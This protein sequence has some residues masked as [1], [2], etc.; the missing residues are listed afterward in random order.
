MPV[1][2]YLTT[3]NTMAQMMTKVNTVI[4]FFDTK[5]SASELVYDPFGT[6]TANNIQVAVQQ[7]EVQ[8]NTKINTLSSTLTTTIN[9]NYTTLDT[10]IDTVETT[11][12][13]AAVAM[14][15][16]LG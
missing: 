1:I 16:A 14:A 15:I 2:P 5:D 4:D 11:T 9:S 8:A 10:K 13:A 3:A 12:L 7:V 6:I